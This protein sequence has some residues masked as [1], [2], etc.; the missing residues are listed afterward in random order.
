MDMKKTTEVVVMG[1]MLA[2]TLAAP[3]NA[4]AAETKIAATT[5]AK[6]ETVGTGTYVL[7]P[8]TLNI[9]A[10]VA[11]SYDSDATRVAVTTANE[12]GM[13]TFGGTSNGGSVRQCESSSL[14]APKPS[15]PKLD[16]G[17]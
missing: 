12:K 11:M 7:E 8:F 1:S 10:N 15:T 3:L 14:S 17:C 6:T 2:L 16:T 13:H 4:H 9:S 5:K